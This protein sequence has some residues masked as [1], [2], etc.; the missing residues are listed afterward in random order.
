MNEDEKWNY[1][2]SLDEELLRGSV[3]TSEWS[4]FLARDAETAYCKGANLAAIL[5]AIA[6]IETW[7]RWGYSSS[8]PKKYP[9]LFEMIEESDFPDD[10]KNEL[11]MLRKYRNKWVHVD[12][13]DDDE[14]L[15]SKP[16]YVESEME[17][18]AK[19]AIKLM[20]QVLYFEQ[21][22]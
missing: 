14:T 22:T 21:G 11:H 12:N 6:A 13:P 3:F 20:L 9:T 1:I 5:A 17:N 16:E 15:V 18:R 4:V 19:S 10:L 2:N 7:L 8:F